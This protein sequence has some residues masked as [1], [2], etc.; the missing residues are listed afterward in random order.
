V[1]DIN[2]D[3]TICGTNTCQITLYLGN[4]GKLIT[5]KRYAFTFY[6]YFS[7]T[8]LS[9]AAKLGG[10]KLLYSVIHK[11][12]E[13]D[14]PMCSIVNTVHFIACRNYFNLIITVQDILLRLNVEPVFELDQFEVHSRLSIT[15]TRIFIM[16][17]C[18]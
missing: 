10:L 12:V 11:A 14:I 17:N 7:R 5:V 2:Y 4:E 15:N 8:P 3:E 16:C 9:S 18:I 13:H 1:Q 6:K